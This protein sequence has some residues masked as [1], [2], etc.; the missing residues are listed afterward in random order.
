MGLLNF[1][2]PPCW[3][4]GQLNLMKTEVISPFSMEW[5]LPCLVERE[6]GFVRRSSMSYPEASHEELKYD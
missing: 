1:M 6:T 4:E 3:L 5:G 2:E